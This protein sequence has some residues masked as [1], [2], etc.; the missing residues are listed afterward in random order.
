[1]E[2][3][4]ALSM[5]TK[6]GVPANKIMVGVS[7]YGRQFGM[8]DPNCIGKD[9]TFVGPKSSATPGRCTNT[10]EYISNAEIKEIIL[11]KPKA[12]LINNNDNSKTLIYDDNWV[13]YMD[14]QDKLRRADLYE[15]L[16]FGGVVD[17]AIDLIQ[18]GKGDSNDPIKSIGSCQPG[19]FGLRRG[20]DSCNKRKSPTSPDGCDDDDS[21]RSIYCNNEGIS[22]YDDDPKTMWANTK[23]DGAWCAAV[24]AWLSKRDTPKYVGKSF[25]NMISGFLNGP[26][27]L[28]CDILTQS[29][30]SSNCIIPDSCQ[31]PDRSSTASMQHILRSFHNVYEASNDRVTCGRFN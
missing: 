26:P 2:T 4:N 15:S 12:R 16:K 28:R 29:S 25:P 21:W 5:I 1:M 23:A 8:T 22:K 30:S 13:S 9:C 17:W 11:Q 24:S 18:F 3:Y 6:A 27:Q 10:P 7:S 19:Q 31:G 14:D 20:Y